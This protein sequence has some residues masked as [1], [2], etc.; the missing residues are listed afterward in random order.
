[1]SWQINLENLEGGKQFPAFLQGDLP[2]PKLWQFGC[3]SVQVTAV[4]TGFCQDS[5]IPGVGRKAADQRSESEAG[6][7]Q[8]C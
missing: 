5:V 4:D 6:S 1:M 3:Q 2:F 8:H 7:R